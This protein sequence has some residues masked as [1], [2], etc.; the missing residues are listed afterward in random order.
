MLWGAGLAFA[1]MV[2]TSE[3][4]SFRVVSE[5]ERGLVATGDISKMAGFAHDLL[6]CCRRRECR[7]ADCCTILGAALLSEY[8]RQFSR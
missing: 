6:G 8:G 2:L 3:A 5:V 4:C 7:D 1:I